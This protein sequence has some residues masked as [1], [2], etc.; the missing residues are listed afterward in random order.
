MLM[1]MDDRAFGMDDVAGPLPPAKTQKLRFLMT[2][3]TEPAT[4]RMV[5]D[6]HLWFLRKRY[7]S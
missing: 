4:H 3:N 6:A 2:D 7:G 5:R 1:M